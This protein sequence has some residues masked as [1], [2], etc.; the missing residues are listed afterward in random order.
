MVRRIA[1]RCAVVALL[2]VLGSCAQTSTSPSG[3]HCPD[4]DYP[5]WC[6]QNKGCCPKGFPVSCG[7]KCYRTDSEA[8]RA[9]SARVD[10][11]YRE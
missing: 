2:L 5:L 6:E 4:E 9:C 8:R 11:C 1:V 10:T 3:K 7:G